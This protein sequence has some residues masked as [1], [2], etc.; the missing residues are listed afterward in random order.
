MGGQ[1]YSGWLSRTI[2]LFNATD[3]SWTRVGHAPVYAKDSVC[4]LNGGRL[5]MMLG[6]QGTGE[7]S[8]GRAQVPA[9]KAGAGV[10]AREGRARCGRSYHASANESVPPHITLNI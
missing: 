5:V 7:Q 6:L 8:E 4:A 1:H 2:W 9:L 10:M 3:D